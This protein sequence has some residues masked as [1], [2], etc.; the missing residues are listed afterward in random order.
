MGSEKGSTYQKVSKVTEPTIEE[1][2][3]TCRVI[4]IEHVHKEEV[5][6]YSPAKEAEVLKHAKTALLRGCSVVYPDKRKVW[7]EVDWVVKE[8]ARFEPIWN[9]N[10]ERIRKKR[11]EVTRYPDG[12][13]EKRGLGEF[14]GSYEED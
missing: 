8:S 12:R 6:V 10:G 1:I 7:Y 5:I 9:K 13:T 3:A 2:L 4:V 14:W 11:I